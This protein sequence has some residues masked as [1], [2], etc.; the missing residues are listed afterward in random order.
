MF[1]KLFIG[2]PFLFAALPATTNY[3]LNSYDFGSGGA[4][5]SSTSNY[6]LE[7]STGNLSGQTTITSNYSTKPG[8]N[9]TQQANVPKI[10]AFDNGSGRYYNKLHFVIDQQSNPSDALYALQ[11]STSSNFSS[12][13]SYVKSDL[14]IGASLTLSDYQTYSAW[15]GA[16]GS[17]IIGLASSTTYYLRAKATQGKF[18][19]TAWGPSATAST[20][21]PSLSFSVSPTTV[22]IGS[23][24]PATVTNAGSS[25]SLAFDTNANSGGDIYI[26]GQNSGLLSTATGN[27]IVAV[28]G[29]LNSL[30]RGFGA[31]VTSTGQSS[32]GPLS[33]VNPYNLSSANVGITDLTIR[34]MITS[35]T[36]VVSGTASVLLKAKA[37]S[38]DKAANDYREVITILASSSF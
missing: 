31:Q 35:S 21:S 1:W 11:I 38:T 15:G 10:S 19:E 23:L 8:F 17:D 20:V 36:P 28:S 24:L 22:A 4:A 30:S 27:T 2:L 37:T 33:A 12:G 13:I 29:D 25:I 32:G 6:A 7:G 14:T 3:Q 5:N 34:K 16:S 26:S 9:E 18:T